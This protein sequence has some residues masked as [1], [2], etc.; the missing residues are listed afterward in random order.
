M[1]RHAVGFGIAGTHVADGGHDKAFI[2]FG[3]FQLVAVQRQFRQ[4]QRRVLSQFRQRCMGGNALVLDAHAFGGAVHQAGLG[5]NDTVVFVDAAVHAVDLGDV[6]IR[7]E[8]GALP[9]AVAGLLSGLE[10]HVD[11]SFRA[12]FVQFH[13]QSAHGGS[14]AVV[15]ALV[16]HAGLAALVG[17]VDQVFDGQRVHFRTERDAGSLGMFAVVDG[18]HVVALIHDLDGRRILLQKFDDP[19]VGGSLLV[20]EVRVLMDLVS[21]FDRFLKLFFVAHLNASYF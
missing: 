2:A 10:D 21:Q 12:E 20:G 5:L 14:V 13:R 1:G 18:V 15:A 4:R 6:V 11:V 3:L 16:T 19:L 17:L 8:V 7:D 9:G